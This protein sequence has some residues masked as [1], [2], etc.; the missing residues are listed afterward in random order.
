VLDGFGG[1]VPINIAQVSGLGGG[2]QDG[3]S[4][5]C[6]PYTIGLGQL[7]QSGAQKQ[8]NLVDAVNL[9][10]GRHQFK[11]GVDYRRL[12]PFAVPYNPEV[13]YFYFSES[14]VESNSPF[15][16]SIAEATAYPLYKNFSAFAQD[17]WKV[18]QR[19]SLSLGLRWDVNPAPG[20]TQGLMPY[21][22]PG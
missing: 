21:T 6:G 5:F 22:V 11:F 13:D 12:A 18:L 3:F 15:T 8:W 10:L 14:S 16:F 1:G 2:S 4:C 17:D 9:S 19:L 20:V 7:Q